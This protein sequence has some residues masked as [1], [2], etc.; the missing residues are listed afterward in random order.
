MVLT[1][2]E[3]QD[4]HIKAISHKITSDFYQRS[5]FKGIRGGRR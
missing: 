1:V 3:T 4:L 2:T 5:Y